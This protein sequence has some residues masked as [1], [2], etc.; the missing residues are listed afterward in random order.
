MKSATKLVIAASVIG[1][2]GVFAL[3]FAAGAVVAAVL[4][5]ISSTGSSLASSPPPVGH[6]VVVP[7][8]LLPGVPAGG[9][10]D[11]FPDGQCTWWAA[12]NHRVTWNGDAW[13]WFENSLIAG[14]TVEASPSV[15]DIVVWGPGDGYSQFGHV[16]IVVATTTN[17]YTVSEANYAGLG[18]VDLRTIKWPDPATEG[19]IQ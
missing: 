17:T 14:A 7:P 11:Y 3:L 15:G 1:C 2:G 12:K 16:A 19:F 9:Y 10:P 8:D 6:L 18:V 4:P 13:Q 5:G